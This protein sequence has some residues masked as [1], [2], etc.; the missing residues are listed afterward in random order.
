MVGDDRQRQLCYCDQRGKRDGFRYEHIKSG[1]SD[2][3]LGLGGRI[4]LRWILDDYDFQ[5]KRFCIYGYGHRAISQ[6][7]LGACCYRAVET[8][9]LGRSDYRDLRSRY[10]LRNKRRD[11]MHGQRIDDYIFQLLNLWQTSLGLVSKHRWGRGYVH[12]AG[13]QRPSYQYSD[14]GARAIRSSHCYKSWRNHR[15]DENS[16][17]SDT[18]SAHGHIYADTFRLHEYCCYRDD[19]QHRH[20]CHATGDRGNDS[21]RLRGIV[22]RMVGKASG[23]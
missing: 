4:R 14:G 21:A 22:L 10:D 18:R 1:L 2:C 20:G 16:L 9:W 17:H 3:C 8:A 6:L 23:L 15:A 13:G 12:D 11:E 19:T 7:D 5:R